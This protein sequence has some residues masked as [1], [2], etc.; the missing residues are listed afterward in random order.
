MRT[1]N[2]NLAHS[3][4]PPL[5]YIYRRDGDDSTQRVTRRCWST[6][7]GANLCWGCQCKKPRDVIGADSLKTN[8]STR[9]GSLLLTKATDFFIKHWLNKIKCKAC[10][11]FA[12][13]QNNISHFCLI[14]LNI[15]IHTKKNEKYGTKSIVIMK[16]SELLI[17]IG[18]KKY[19]IKY[20]LKP[21]NIIIININWKN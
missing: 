19:S 10:F 7:S 4:Q 3:E 9:T 20:Y 16:I 12:S 14:K 13:C 8:I 2:Y 21:S 17:I 5:L 15:S 6:R 18:K 1:G 11:L